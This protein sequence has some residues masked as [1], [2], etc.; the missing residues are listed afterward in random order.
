[1]LVPQAQQIHS[2]F[3]HVPLQAITLD[4]ADTHSVSITVD[5]ILTDSI[6]I[7][8]E[9]G[10]ITNQVEGNATPTSPSNNTNTEENSTEIAH[11]SQQ[12]LPPP[13]PTSTSSAPLNVPSQAEKPQNSD[14]GDHQGCDSDELKESNNVSKDSH[15]PQPRKS[16][17][18]QES[19]DSSE[20]NTQHNQSN[21]RLRKTA[22]K[23]APENIQLVET[24][25]S[26]SKKHCSS[27]TN[28]PVSKEDYSHLFTSLQERKAELLRKAKRYIRVHQRAM[29]IS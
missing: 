20:A 22:S 2:M 12:N 7:P 9:G 21:L 23:V 27:D 17:D 15:D 16:H 11:S 24:I 3:P 5:R 18:L 14:S 28:F 19:H 1:M 13:Q 6:Y 26:S 4:L 8:G 25:E 29:F 10:V